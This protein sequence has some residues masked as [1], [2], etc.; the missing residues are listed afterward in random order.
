MEIEDSRSLGRV[1]FRL[2]GGG[3]LIGAAF[4][5]FLLMALD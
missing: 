3:L 1:L 4:T 5:A 2:S